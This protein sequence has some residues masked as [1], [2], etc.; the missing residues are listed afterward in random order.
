MAFHKPNLI[1]FGELVNTLREKT[2]AY[3]QD[4]L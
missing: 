2:N 4:N 3:D 1:V